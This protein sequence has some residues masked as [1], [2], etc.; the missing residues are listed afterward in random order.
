MLGGGPSPTEESCSGLGSARAAT[1]GI[2]FLLKRAD[3]GSDTGPSP[4]PA[5][6]RRAGRE[7]LYFAL[8]F[9]E[10]FHVPQAS[11]GDSKYVDLSLM[12]HV[13][14]AQ[15]G[16]E[17]PPGTSMKFVVRDITTRAQMMDLY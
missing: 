6:R 13:L 9:N 12:P 3:M 5:P 15:Q 16:C 7:T 17:V 8:T 14:F 11:Q 4:R 10:V 1:R 2:W